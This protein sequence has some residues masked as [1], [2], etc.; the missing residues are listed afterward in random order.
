MGPRNSSR[1]TSPGCTG[2]S[3][4]A[5]S[6]Y[7]SVIVDNL[8]LFRPSIRP[9][10]YDSPLIVCANRM[11]SCE[12]SPQRFQAISWGSGEIA[13]QDGG[14]E[15]YQLAASDLR[16]IRREPFGT[17]RCWRISSASAPRK[18]LIIGRYVS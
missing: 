13:Q 12:I 17:R 16:D 4:L 11:L 10:K 3:F 15:L 18:L 9:L 8:D 5:M 6:G 2:A 7:L 14:V 1:S